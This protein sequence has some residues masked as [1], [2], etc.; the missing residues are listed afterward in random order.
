[1]KYYSIINDKPEVNSAKPQFPRFT[2]EGGWAGRL[3]KLGAADDE[4]QLNSWMLRLMSCLQILG[5]TDG[6]MEV[7]VGVV[8]LLNS[9]PTV[10][11]AP[12]PPPVGF[13]LFLLQLKCLS[14]WP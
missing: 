14:R 11:N 1:M 2:R 4:K 13:T 5:W 12:I 9:F 7:G 6:R 10:T 3:R 8:L